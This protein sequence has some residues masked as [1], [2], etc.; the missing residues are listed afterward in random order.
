MKI[1]RWCLCLGPL[2]WRA[3]NRNYWKQNFCLLGFL[4]SSRI[5][6]SPASM[7][8]VISFLAVCLVELRSLLGVVS[9]TL[10]RWFR[11]SK[12]RRASPNHSSQPKRNPCRSLGGEPPRC[13]EDAAAVAKIPQSAAESRRG[14]A[15]SQRDRRRGRRW[16]GWRPTSRWPSGRSSSGSRWTGSTSG[17]LSTRTRRWTNDW[18]N[19]FPF[20]LGIQIHSSLLCMCRSWVPLSP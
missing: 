6:G 2:I 13:P 18:P 14:D 4:Y 11:P 9:G 12:E 17:L 10:D 8:G 15:A 5:L 7:S 19:L 3:L 20:S 16:C 1:G